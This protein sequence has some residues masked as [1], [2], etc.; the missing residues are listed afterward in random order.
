MGHSNLDS[1]FHYAEVSPTDEW[2]EEAEAAIAR[3]GASLG[4][5]INGDKIVKNI[6]RQARE[7]TKVS[8]IIEDLVH[9]LISDHKKNTGQEIRFKKIGKQDVFF[10]FQTKEVK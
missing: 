5:I 1:T 8:I 7:E 2:I 9:T 4:K 3:I 6:I 10:Y